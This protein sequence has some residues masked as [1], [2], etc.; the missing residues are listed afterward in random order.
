MSP[1]NPD[2]TGSS[3]DIDTNRRLLNRYRYIEHEGL[4][5]LAARAFTDI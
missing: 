4:R 1:L 3:I 5:V 2:T